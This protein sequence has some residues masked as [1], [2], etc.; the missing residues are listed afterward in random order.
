[1]STADIQ[2][3][4][5]ND[6]QVLGNDPWAYANI[7]NLRSGFVTP[8]ARPA[9]E[10]TG[11]GLSLGG[12]IGSHDYA[13][14]DLTDVAWTPQQVIDAQVVGH[15]GAAWDG[16]PTVA[17][18]ADKPGFG[19]FN[20]QPMMSGDTNF[21]PGVVPSEE[22]G[23]GKPPGWVAAHM[24]VAQGINPTRSSYVYQGQFADGGAYFRTDDVAARQ[25]AD[26]RAPWWPATLD[27]PGQDPN[28]KML[29]P[30]SAVLESGPSLSVSQLVQRVTGGRVPGWGVQ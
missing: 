18:R 3:L 16:P 21:S 15:S 9:G 6:G 19:G 28:S 20:D 30:G 25:R 10:N 12:V 1:M 26:T 27:Q 11:R 4:I 2:A 17:Y 7:D 5:G 13:R 22:V 29:Y 8:P 23:T 24:P 14:S